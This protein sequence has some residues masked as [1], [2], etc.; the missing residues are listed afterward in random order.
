MRIIIKMILIKTDIGEMNRCFVLGGWDCSGRVRNV[1]LIGCSVE[2]TLA[3]RPSPLPPSLLPHSIYIF[4]FSLS[5]R[6][7][8]WVSSC[9]GVV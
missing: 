7:G 5:S 6:M 4:E 2:S 8:G 1:L 9:M 3:A